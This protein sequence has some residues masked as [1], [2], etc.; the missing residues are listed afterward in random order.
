MSARL[1][2]LSVVYFD[3]S[4]DSNQKSRS[5][6]II[7]EW[8]YPLQWLYRG[9]SSTHLSRTRTWRIIII[10]FFF[11]TKY[12]CTISAYYCR[13][14]KK[15]LLYYI[16]LLNRITSTNRYPSA[17]C[18]LYVSTHQSS[19]SASAGVK[20]GGERLCGAKYGNNWPPRWPASARRGGLPCTI[21]IFIA[22]FEERKKTSI[23]SYIITV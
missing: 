20:R 7:R 1:G 19:L 2:L 10:F 8:I 15:Y 12:I 18:I 9:P 14:V 22:R 4:N 16:L 17:V 13:F 21:E 11:F 5:D 23:F 3:L 6:I